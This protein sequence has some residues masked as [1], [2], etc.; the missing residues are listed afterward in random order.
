MYMEVSM[1]SEHIELILLVARII[2]ELI[3]NHE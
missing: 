1:D 2:L 3:R